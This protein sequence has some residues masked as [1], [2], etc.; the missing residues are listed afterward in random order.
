MIQMDIG[1]EGRGDI[2]KV[3]DYFKGLSFL[4]DPMQESVYLLQERMAKYPMARP[5]NI[6]TGTLG[7]SWTTEVKE[8][9]N[10]IDGKI[11]TRVV[12]APWVQS[13]KFQARIHKGFWQT[14]EQ[15][16]RRSAKDIEQLFNRAIETATS[17]FSAT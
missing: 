6:R 17:R 9:T 7:R 16:M 4:K 3:I 11:G 8:T 14:D 15:V 12:Y 5:G 1:I 10:G 2:Q 13:G